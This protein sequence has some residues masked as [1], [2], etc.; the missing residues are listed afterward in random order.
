MVRWATSLPWEWQIW[1]SGEGVSLIKPVAPVGVIGGSYML[2]GDKWKGQSGT[3]CGA[4]YKTKTA[5]PLLEPPPL[6]PRWL[7]LGRPLQSPRC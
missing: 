7:R 3:G 5:A 6:M 4:D 1:K 2:S